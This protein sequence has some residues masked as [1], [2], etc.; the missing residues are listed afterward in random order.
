MAARTTTSPSKFCKVP[1][2]T[3]ERLSLYLQFFE[4]Q[5][6]EVDVFEIDVI[7]PG[8]LAEHLVDLYQYEG[9]REAMDAYFPAIVENNT[10]EGQLVGIPYYT[11]AGLLYYRTDLLATYGFDGPPTTWTELTEMGSNHSGGG[12]V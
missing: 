1:E 2:S 11:G 7:W 9:V 10:V 8:D 3:T 6:G 12:A 4:A 5:S